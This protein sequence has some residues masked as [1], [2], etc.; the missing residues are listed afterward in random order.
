M[1]TYEFTIWKIS[2]SCTHSVF[3]VE[4][5]HTVNDYCKKGGK[6]AYFCEGFNVNCLCFEE[7]NEVWNIY[8]HSRNSGHRYK[9]FAVW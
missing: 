2:Q 9:V 1:Y 5:I 8:F 6:T 4:H 7:T 3:K